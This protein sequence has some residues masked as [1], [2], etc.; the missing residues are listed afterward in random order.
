MHP[1]QSMEARGSILA[2]GEDRGDNPR[3]GIHEKTEE[4]NHK[5]ALKRRMS[6]MEEN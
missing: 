4:G 3:Q 5:K 2:R 6:D 1:R